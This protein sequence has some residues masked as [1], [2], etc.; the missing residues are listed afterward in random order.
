[1]DCNCHDHAS[2]YLSPYGDA[3]EWEG[4]PLRVIGKR[5]GAIHSYPCLGVIDLRR[6]DGPWPDSST[7]ALDVLL[8]KCE[9]TSHTTTT[10]PSRVVCLQPR[11]HQSSTRYR[12]FPDSH[13]CLDL[14]TSACRLSNKP[15]FTS[16]EVCCLIEAIF[17]GLDGG[18]A[19]HCLHEGDSQT[20]IDAAYKARPPLTR[21]CEIRSIEDL[22]C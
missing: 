3:V 11:L 5:R 8:G 22:F 1:M 7:L 12:L 14:N 20:F 15:T 10:L 4:E 17:S 6:G 16:D 13:F 21:H 2:E 19:I 9:Y 18:N